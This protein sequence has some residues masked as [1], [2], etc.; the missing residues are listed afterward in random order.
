MAS[1]S[2]NLAELLNGDVTVTATD[3]ADG[4]VT[5]AKIANDAVTT[6]K[7]PDDAITA[8]KIG[9]GAVEGAMTTQFGRRNLII[10][11]A[12]QVAQRGTSITVSNNNWLYLMD[13]FQYDE[14]GA[15]SA[16]LDVTQ[17]TDAP[18]GF[19]YSLKMT[20]TTADAA[21]A[22]GDGLRLQ[23]LIEAQDL[24]SLAH[25][26]SN[27][28][29]ATLSFWVKSKTTGTNCIWVYKAD[30]SRQTSFAYTIDAADT[31][32]YKTIT[33]PADTSGV[34]NNDN[35]EGMRISW[36]LAAGTDFNSGTLDSSWASLTSA[37][38][39]VGQVNNFSSTS[40]YWAI[41]GVQLEVGDTATPF[42]HR[43]YGEEL[44][45]CQRY[46]EISRASKSDFGGGS[47]TGYAYHVANGSGVG[48]TS[49]EGDRMFFKV[50]KRA[51]PTVTPYSYNGTS[52][53][54][55]GIN[56]GSTNTN[57]NIRDNEVCFN[58]YNNAYGSFNGWFD[59]EADAEL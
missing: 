22:S 38:R 58:M 8:T 54:Y 23:Y 19:G 51:N 15:S 33:I 10:N 12:M 55:S 9:S 24:Q 34:I 39:A 11:G 25:G 45:L 36:Y 26:T 35:G 3:I 40:D 32:E 50:T 37:N 14:N 16:V 30:S 5:S 13:R 31:W 48:T 7:I 28:K 21:L 4:S 6:A 27:A 20:A 43:S 44:A 41:T 2:K 17:S 29:T 56:G 46:Y 49:R 52:D 1:N 42:E 59:W 53:A 57:Y 18:D 47:M